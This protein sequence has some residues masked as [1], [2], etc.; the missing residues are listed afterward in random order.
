MLIK[1]W[2][3]TKIIQWKW[4][5]ECAQNEHSNVVMALRLVVLDSRRWSCTYECAVN[6]TIAQHV[7]SSSACKW[8]SWEVRNIRMRLINNNNVLLLG[9]RIIFGRK[10]IQLLI[11][12]L[13]LTI[14][15]YTMVAMFTRF[16]MWIIHNSNSSVAWIF[17]NSRIGYWKQEWNAMSTFNKTIEVIYSIQANA[18]NKI[19]VRLFCSLGFHLLFVTLDPLIA[20]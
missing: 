13:R 17:F 20:R 16:I 10:K 6:W 2:R 18:W 4:R 3:T 15:R 12:S 7:H 14:G 9:L 5:N 19:R 11:L 1:I 8:S